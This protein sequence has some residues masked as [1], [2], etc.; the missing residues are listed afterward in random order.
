MALSYD[1]KEV[2]YPGFAELGGIQNYYSLRKQENLFED[3]YF[4]QYRARSVVSVPKR[5]LNTIYINKVYCCKKSRLV[6]SRRKAR[7][8]VYVYQNWL[9]TNEISPLSLVTK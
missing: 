4:T 6:L 7:M 3:V 8:S 9:Q 2:F 5:T 1:L